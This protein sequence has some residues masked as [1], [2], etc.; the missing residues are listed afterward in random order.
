MTDD[1]SLDLTGVGKLAE[2]V[3]P[4]SWNRLVRTACDTFSDLI[5]PISELTYGLGQLIQ[6]K[7]EGMADAQ[8]VLA[9]DAVRRARD[10][11][12]ASGR[13]PSGKPKARV[14]LA[15]LDGAAIETDDDIRGLW[16]NLI[17]NE[18][19]DNSVHPE[20]PG[21]LGRLSSSDAVALAQVGERSPKDPVQRAVRAAA[22]ALQIMGTGIS[23]VLNEGSDFSRQHLYNLHLIV[24]QSGRWTLTLVG[25]QFLNAVADPAFEVD[26]AEQAEAA[27]GP[28]RRR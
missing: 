19:V 9:A 28:S 10:K 15:S 3:P 24:Q 13:V 18:L 14:L 11:V 26:A 23:L 12:A 25:E 4:E 27:D 16:A 2:A 7:F 21:I 20:F 6:A 17:A 5:A 22:E 8:R 1:K